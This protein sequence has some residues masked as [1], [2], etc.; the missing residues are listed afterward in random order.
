MYKLLNFTEIASNALLYTLNDIEYDY[1]EFNKTNK[2][3]YTYNLNKLI[4]EFCKFGYSKNKIIVETC[5]PINNWRKKDRGRGI[6]GYKYSISDE[7]IKINIDK[8]NIFLNSYFKKIEKNTLLF[9][10]PTS[11]IR[12]F[13]FIYYNINIS[14]YRPS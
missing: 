4:K 3:L 11:R 12:Y 7:S 13:R 10:Y 6:K 2:E 5:S 9:H 8:L 14:K 1:F